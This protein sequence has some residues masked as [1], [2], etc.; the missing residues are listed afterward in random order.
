MARGYSVLFEGAQATLLDTWHTIGL[1][2]TASDSY[3]IEDVFVAATQ[4]RAAP[5]SE[6]RAA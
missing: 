3:S 4:L 6:G 5:V 2:G 1:R